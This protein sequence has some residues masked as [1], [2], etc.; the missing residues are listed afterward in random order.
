MG[1]SWLRVGL[2]GARARAFVAGLRA[3]P[4]VEVTALCDIDPATLAALGDELGIERRYAEFEAMLDRRYRRRRHRDADAP[5]RAAGDRRAR[6]RQARAVGGDGRRRPGAV[7]GAGHGRAAVGPLLHARP[8]T[9]AIDARPCS[10]AR[11]SAPASSAS[12]TTPRAATSTTAATCTPTP[13]AGRPGGRSG[14]SART[15]APTAPTA[16]GR[17][18]SGSTTGSVCHLPGLGPAHRARHGMDDTVTMLCQTAR[19]ALIDDPLRHAVAAAAQHDALRAAGHDRRLPRPARH[20]AEE[21]WSGCEGRSPAPRGMGA[22]H[23]LRGPPARPLAATRRPRRRGPGTAAATT[24]SCATGSR[25][26]GATPHRRS[27]SCAGL[28]FTLPGL[29]SEQSIAQGGA[30]LPVPDPRDW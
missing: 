6:R 4:G 19:G 12:R 30:P 18:C 29:I 20:P 25:P 9:T 14:R 28:D 22:A 10:S 23:G 7:P 21:T 2:V 16:S 13:P 3:L 27:T 26:S 1:E 17:C 5:A 8:R 24:S 15:A 11:W